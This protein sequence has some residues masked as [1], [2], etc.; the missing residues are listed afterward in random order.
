MT[1][2]AGLLDRLLGAPMSAAQPN[3]LLT[4]EDYAAARKQG[5][6]G[7]GTGLLAAS[8]PGPQNLGQRLAS[9][10]GAGQQA[11]QGAL[12]SAGNLAAGNQQFQARQQ[13]LQVGEARKAIFAQFP[14]PADASN[15]EAVNAWLDQV[16][17]RLVPVDPEGSQQLLQ[18]R[19][20]M[21]ERGQGQAVQLGDQ[22]TTFVPGK[23]FWNAKANGGQGGWVQSIERNME[24]DAL[25]MK[26]LALEEQRARTDAAREAARMAR[27]DRLTKAFDSRN[28]II[29]D[30]IP[31]IKQALMT[32]DQAQNSKN[33]NDRRL[34]YSSSIINF[35][36]A[37]DPRLQLRW[38]TLN[39]VKTYI[40]ASFTGKLDVLK[41]KIL[42]G[43]LPVRITQAML[44]HLNRLL[45]MEKSDYTVRYNGELTRHPELEGR[46][47]PPEE[48]FN[49]QSATDPAEQ[50]N[51]DMLFPNRAQ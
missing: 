43:T 50:D 36:Q 47:A 42:N 45:E 51:I 29:V 11:Y 2:P 49:E 23:G 30:R 24:S 33:E 22:A 16:I 41:E 14:P 39:F 9:G 31:I 34:L 25:E 19:K 32:L 21:V 35:L 12:G 37:A 17:P 38:Q 10:I 15:P 20:S 27:G 7:L 26:K 6:I 28:K 13:Q 8:G 46:L 18:L 3:G 4:S 5:L 44:N 48:I 40:D 1:A